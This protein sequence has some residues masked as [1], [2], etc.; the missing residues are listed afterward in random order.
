MWAERTAFV[1][2]PDGLLTDVLRKVKQPGE[3]DK[4][5]LDAPG[6]R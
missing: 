6:R 3:H 1:I 2:G 5:A 4:L